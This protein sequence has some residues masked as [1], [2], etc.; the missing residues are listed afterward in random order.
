M[1]LLFKDEPLYENELINNPNFK[2]QSLRDFSGLELI[3]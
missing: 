2:L 1:T 3:N